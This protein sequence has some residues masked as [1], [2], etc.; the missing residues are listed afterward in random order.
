MERPQSIF[1]LQKV[2]M[3][4]TAMAPPRPSILTTIKRSL[5]KELF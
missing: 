3:D 4:Q 1:S 5:T 2:L